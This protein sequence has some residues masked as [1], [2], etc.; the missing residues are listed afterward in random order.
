VPT[1]PKSL[2]P[3]AQSSSYENSA[4]KQPRAASML[5]YFKN[6][7]IL[8]QSDVSVD[9]DKDIA[10][11]RKVALLSVKGEA[12]FKEQLNSIL[13]ALKYE[14]EKSG[15]GWDRINSGSSFEKLK[16]TTQIN[17]PIYICVIFKW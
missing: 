3:N 2:N 7:K 11:K 17:F 6:L 13:D 16:V 12:P 8:P 15:L 5:N 14:L 10:L 9:T 1:P 4:I